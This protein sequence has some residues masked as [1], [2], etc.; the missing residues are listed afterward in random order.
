MAYRRN[1]KSALS[2]KISAVRGRSVPLEEALAEA[3]APAA[4]EASAPAENCTIL[5]LDRLDFP[6][7]SENKRIYP[8]HIFY[9]RQLESLSFDRL[10]LLYGGNGSGKSTILN[11]IAES[12]N[13]RNRTQG[14]KN[15][16]FDEF[17]R[18]CVPH[19]TLPVTEQCVFVR[20]EDIMNEI[21]LRRD[22]G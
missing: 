16:Y 2:E 19:K 6:S 20:S 14:N 9:E 21:V 13:I 7:V 3:E 12:L 17:V 4:A 18:K 5:Y 15:I 8:Y 22:K 10:T 1:Q 11:I